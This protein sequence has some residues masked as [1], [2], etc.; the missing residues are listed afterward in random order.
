MTL[1]IVLAVLH[2]LALGI[3]LGA[4]YAR[5][6]ALRHGAADAELRPAL[7]ADTWWGASG[8]LFVVTGLWRLLGDTEK[9]TSYYMQNPVFH[10]KL[11]LVALIFALEVWPMVTLLRW[12]RGGMAD[13]RAAGRIATISM[14]QAGLLIAI[15]ALAS[16]MARGA[17]AV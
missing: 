4:V 7:A 15:V 14:L 12:R 3:G 13:G 17:G 5:G 9:A 10:A 8:L 1:R 6:R 2:L 16:A 11:G